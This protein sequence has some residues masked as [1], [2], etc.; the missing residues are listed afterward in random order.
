M[1]SPAGRSHQLYR[2]IGRVKLR[3][4]D[5]RIPVDTNWYKLKTVRPGPYLKLRSK[6]SNV[7]EI[8]V[9]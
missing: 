3:M 8:Q 7:S 2:Y 5:L 6:A 1:S 4:E 9:L